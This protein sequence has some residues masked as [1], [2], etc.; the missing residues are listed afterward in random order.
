MSRHR[1]IVLSE[2]A[3][4][5]VCGSRTACRL[6]VGHGGRD[7]H[8]TRLYGGLGLDPTASPPDGGAGIQ[9]WAL[10][11]GDEVKSLYQGNDK[12]ADEQAG[13][14]FP[15]FTPTVS[16]LTLRSTIGWRPGCAWRHRAWCGR[17]PLSRGQR[18]RSNDRRCMVVTNGGE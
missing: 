16:P 3:A 15:L 6:Q 9:Q 5:L 18:R 14:G 12:L 13:G 4:G 11:V 7:K 8:C 10:V 17:I 1:Q 2:Q